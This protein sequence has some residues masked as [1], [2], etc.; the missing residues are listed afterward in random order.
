MFI[1]ASFQLSR[2]GTSVSIKED[3]VCVYTHT[4]EY[5]H[6]YTQW[7][8]IQLRNS[9]ILPFAVTQ[10]DLERIMGFPCASAGKQ[11][12][13]NVRDL[14]SV[15]RLGRCPGEEKDYPL[16]YSGLENSKDHRVCGVAK[17]WTR[18]SNFQRELC[19]WNKSDKVKYCILSL[20]CGIKTN[21]K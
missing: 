4:M 9:S 16:Q 19:Q 5:T 8:I 10:M 1:E 14:C 15:P 6:T 18:L 11:F 12:T 3:V 7:N 21:C 2:H 13:C 17:S 20:I